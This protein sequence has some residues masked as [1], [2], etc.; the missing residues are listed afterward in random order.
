MLLGDIC[1]M[2]LRPED[3]ANVWGPG[4]HLPGRRPA[5]PT[6]FR[7]EQSKVFLEL[8]GRV[9]NPILRSRLADVV[10]TNNRAETKAAIHAISA[11]SDCVEG[12]LAGTYVAAFPRHGL[13]SL[14]A[15]RFVQRGLQIAHATSR[16]GRLPD[17]ITSAAKNLYG[18][19]KT[20]AAF[21]VFRSIAELGLYYELLDP[22]KVAADVEAVAATANS[23]S[24]PIA[25]K[26]VLDFGASLY[27]KLQNEEGVRRCQMGAVDQL[28]AM[29][30]R[31]SSAG[32]QAHWVMEALQLL[33]HVKGVEDKERELEEELRRLQKASVRE[34][35]SIP[36]DLVSDEEKS[37]ILQAFGD[38]DLSTALFNFSLLGSARLVGDLRQEALQTLRTS[39]IVSMLGAGYIDGEGRTIKNTPGADGQT[40]PDED[41]FRAT[42][43]TSESLR[44]GYTVANRIEP[45]RQTIAQRFTISEVSI[46]PIVGCSFL[47]PQSHRPIVALGIARFFQGDFM[48][49]TYLLLPQIEPCL[50]HILKLNGYDPS[51]RFA[52]STEEDLS[53]SGLIDRMRAE[54]GSILTQPILSEIELLFDKRPGPALR[55]EMAHGQIGA[56]ACFHPDIIYACWLIYRLCC[57]PL[58]ADWERVIKPALLKSV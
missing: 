14:D 37:V 4:A 21:F 55:H 10:W 34:M 8:L 32:A 1:G 3:R 52:D 42:I 2:H 57:L 56:A 9:Q 17:N 18:R 7:G 22:A 23:D 51:K 15:G 38:V 19:A 53:L 28:L 26:A 24:Y 33:G 12:L 47:V 5:H 30:S 48:S 29:R 36:I 50:R 40:E 54:L 35:K 31:V 58:L 6:D 39:P 43:N 11:Y 45:A 16:K 49:A 13:S 25:V 20:E 46:A 27:A 44:R 41:W